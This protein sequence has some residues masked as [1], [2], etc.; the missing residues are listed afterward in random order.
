M[1]IDQVGFLPTTTSDY[2][3]EIASI[4]FLPR[5]NMRCPYCHNK[6]LVENNFTGG[7]DIADAIERIRSR[8]GFIT[9]VVITGG[10]PTIYDDLQKYIDI[11]KDM[12]LRVKVDTNGLRPD[13]LKTLNVDYIAMDFKTDLNDYEHVLSG[14]DAPIKFIESL[15]YLKTLPRRWYEVR[16]VTHSA[17]INERTIPTMLSL[18][19]GIKRFY[20]TPFKPGDILD[21]SFNLHHIYTNDE[22]DSIV[23]QFKHPIKQLTNKMDVF[24]RK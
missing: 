16:T 19:D 11:I 3:G 7:M 5:C 12:G 22:F 15:N 18:L 2:P 20:I 24:V 13:V 4:I 1:N 10:E 14:K 17:L 21:S 6:S 23:E 9:G 8:K